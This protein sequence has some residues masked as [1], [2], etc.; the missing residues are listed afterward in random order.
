MTNTECDLAEKGIRN[1]HEVIQN[2]GGSEGKAVDKMLDTIAK[3]RAL[4]A[5]QKLQKQ[6]PVPIPNENPQP[7][8]A[9]KLL[10]H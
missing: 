9:E 4:P 6:E 5:V 7:T 10:V 2:N 1:L 3:I 8:E